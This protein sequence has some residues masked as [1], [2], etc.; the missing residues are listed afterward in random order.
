METNAST[1]PTERVV[2]RY[3][4]GRPGPTVLVVAAIHGNEPGGLEASRRVA[5]RLER[6]RL[7]LRGRFLAL[8]GNLGALA[9]GRRFVDRDLNRLFSPADIARAEARDEPQAHE[10]RELRELLQHL[11]RELADAERVVVF[12]LHSSSAEGE[13][14]CFISDTLA[15]RR[16]VRRIPV[17][18]I[19]GVEEV[20]GGALLEWIQERGHVGV[21]IEGG[22]HLDPRTVDRH[23]SALWLGLVGAGALDEEYVPDASQ[24]RQQLVE[25][26]AGLPRVV[27]IV[28]RHALGHDDGFAMEPGFENF[29]PIAANTLLARDRRGEVRAPRDGRILL[30]L[31]QGQG[32][33]GFFVG[34]DVRP[35]WLRLSRAMRRLGLPRLL[36][37]LPGVERADGRRCTL[38]VDRRIARLYP[39]ELLH[40]C[41][42]RRLPDEAG[43]LVFRRR[44]ESP[45]EASPPTVSGG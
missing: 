11:R 37:L 14:F 16:V 32:D 43:R 24:H 29:E 38:T 2:A 44:P 1:T 27:E 9:Q 4:A 10:E 20:I 5:E 45:D 18:V 25:A 42:F 33:D 19:L 23:E 28:H 13:P 41:G 15:A 35:F 39:A 22:R 30:P 34:A 3:D 6:E 21:A 26:T 17:P 36:P 8:A 7:P 12:D 31:Y 40:L